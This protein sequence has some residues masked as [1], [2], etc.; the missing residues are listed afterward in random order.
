MDRFYLHVFTC[1]L[2][3]CSLA[4]VSIAAESPSYIFSLQGGQSTIT[5]ASDGM[6]ITVTA[7]DPNVTVSNGTVNK[8]TPVR[9]LAYLKSPFN[10]AVVFS[11]ADSERTSMVAISNL[12]LSDDDTVLSLQVTPLK[13]YEGEGLKFYAEKKGELSTDSDENLNSTQIY[14]ETSGSIPENTE[15]PP[16]TFYCA[17]YSTCCKDCC[18]FG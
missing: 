4:G 9:Y 8:T 15:C 17:L 18:I 12:S 7:I 3:V 1:I 13:F 5:N 2:L 16:G 10:A 11:G 14:L 6:M